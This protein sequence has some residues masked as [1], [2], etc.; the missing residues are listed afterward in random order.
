MTL[1]IAILGATGR[2]G[3]QI[4]H[5]AHHDGHQIKALVR[6]KTTAEKILPANIMLIEGNATNRNDMKVTFQETDMVIS[7][8]NTDK[9]TTLSQSIPLI[10]QTME[11]L[12]IRRIVTIGTAGILNS[13][14]YPGL[15]RF[16]SPESKRKSTFA[17]NEHLKVLHSLEASTLDWTIICPTYLPDGTAKGNI[18]VEEDFLPAEGQK[19]TVG[20]TAE[21]AYQTLLTNSY[22]RKRVGICY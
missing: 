18:R 11:D 20:D 6:N 12:Q 9:T 13:R 8:L 17:A 2:V 14:Y 4:T 3:Q 22:I 16:Q 1:K 19:V 10:I 7:A 5:L 21:F 15:Y